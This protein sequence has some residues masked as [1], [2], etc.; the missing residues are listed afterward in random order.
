MG[1]RCI[2]RVYEKWDKDVLPR[3]LCT[4]Y[5]Q[6]D[7]YPDGHGIELKEF[8]DGYK[9]VNGISGDAAE[10]KKIANGAGCLAA[11]LVAHFKQLYPLGMIYLAEKH[12]NEDWANLK[13]LDYVYDVVVRNNE[14]D[15][16]VS[17]SVTGYE[18][19]SSSSTNLKKL[20]RYWK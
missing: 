10:Y 11:Q 18:P 20:K 3:L 15:N 14:E 13:Y 12:D 6:M 2:T 1:T 8:L 5:R 17:L 4:M 16:T 9:L 7:G 19:D